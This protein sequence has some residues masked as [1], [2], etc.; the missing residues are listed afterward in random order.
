MSPP[1]RSRPSYTTAIAIAA[2]VGALVAGGLVFLL[3]SQTAWPSVEA[4]VPASPSIDSSQLDA[5]EQRLR[6]LEAKQIAARVDEPPERVPVTPTDQSKLAKLAQRIAKLETQRIEASALQISHAITA[7]TPL[8]TVVQEN[9]QRILDP[10]LTEL[11]KLKA[12]GALRFL[13]K[14][15]WTDAVVFE[16]IRIGR[17]SQDSAVRAD[18][19]RQ[20]DAHSKSP[21]LVPA[22][23][24]ALT[25]DSVANVR[26]EAAETL[27]NYTSDPAVVQALEQAKQSDQDEGVRRF[28]GRSLERRRRQP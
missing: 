17:T 2:G 12:W 28:A 24:R 27:E 21:A 5:L 9:Q 13:G 4:S 19:W 25:N 16:M 23:L 11:E 20:A 18:V 22:L 6:A 1:T 8:S 7:A 15:A 26:E 3:S 10:R 14:D